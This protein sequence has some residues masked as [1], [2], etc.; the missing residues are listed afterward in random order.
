MRMGEEQRWVQLA[1]PGAETSVTLVTWFETMSPGSLK[2]IVLATDDLEG[3]CER[4]AARG[5]RFGGPIEHAPWGSFATFED[6][7]GNGWVL[8]AA[9]AG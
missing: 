4:L 7:D 1:P 3:D 5:V 2:G 6:P 9:P 8:Q